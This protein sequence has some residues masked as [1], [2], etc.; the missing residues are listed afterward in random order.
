MSVSQDAAPICNALGL[1]KS[2]LVDAPYLTQALSHTD[3]ASVSCDITTVN[4]WQRWPFFPS[5]S[6]SNMWLRRSRHL[7]GRAR[8]GG[9][10]GCWHLSLLGRARLCDVGVRVGCRDRTETDMTGPLTRARLHAGSN[11]AV[12]HKQDFCSLHWACS[13]THSWQLRSLSQ[14]KQRCEPPASQQ[15]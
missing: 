10:A 3:R 7:P 5:C 6:A 8:R 13:E 4:G 12:Q 11:T 1:G 14:W 15:C 2:P 9:A